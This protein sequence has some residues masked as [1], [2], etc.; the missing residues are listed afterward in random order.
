MSGGAQRYLLRLLAERGMPTPEPGRIDVYAALLL[1]AWITAMRDTTEAQRRTVKDHLDV[2][3]DWLRYRQCSTKEQLRLVH[4]VHGWL[5]ELWAM[6]DGAPVRFQTPCAR[7]LA[8]RIED[9]GYRGL[10]E[11]DAS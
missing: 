2:L 6:M 5:G 4:L 9:V 11:R 8:M 1:G 3:H 7:T 10:V